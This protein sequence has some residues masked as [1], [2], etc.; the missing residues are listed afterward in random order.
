M[1][2]SANGI[3][4]EENKTNKK[5]KRGKETVGNT[6][7]GIVDDTGQMIRRIAVRL[8]RPRPSFSHHPHAQRLGHFEDSRDSRFFARSA[9]TL[10]DSLLF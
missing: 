1:P 10:E 3:Q 6:H 9:T 5:E 8:R 4:K 2:A 7:V